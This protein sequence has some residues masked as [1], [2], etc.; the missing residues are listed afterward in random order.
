MADTDML[1]IYVIIA[2]ASSITALI[3]AAYYWARLRLEHKRSSKTEEYYTARLLVEQKRADDA[4]KY[5]NERLI[6]EAEKL[7]IEAGKLE[8][9]KLKVA[10]EQKKLDL[11]KA[12]TNGNGGAPK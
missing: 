6:D 11:R 12:E 4:E 10:I 8:Q 1:M 3:T 2:T 9:E 5:Y 7:A